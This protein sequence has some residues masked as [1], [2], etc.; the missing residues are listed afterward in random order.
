[1]ERQRQSHLKKTRSLH[2]FAGWL[3]GRGVGKWNGHCMFRSL[4]LYLYFCLYLYLS[5][6]GSLMC[7][8]WLCRRGVG[9][10]SGLCITPP[11]HASSTNIKQCTNIVQ[12]ITI[13]II[14]IIDLV[15]VYCTKHHQSQYLSLFISPPFCTEPQ[16][17]RRSDVALC[18]IV[19]GVPK[20]R[21]LRALL[22]D[23]IFWPKW[24]TVSQSCPNGPR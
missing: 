9:M 1:M 23:Q 3:R 15:I 18:I 11:T 4:T 5:L 7:W 13:V 22:G 14:I 6:P 2:W 20:N 16:P 17:S 24:L 21:I 10:W 19:L 8:G 12:I